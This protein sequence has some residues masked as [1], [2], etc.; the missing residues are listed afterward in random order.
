M[1]NVH[2]ITMIV[3]QILMRILRKQKNPNVSSPAQLPEAMRYGDAPGRQRAGIKGQ[4]KQYRYFKRMEYLSKLAAR[5]ERD[6][7]CLRIAN[8]A[9]RTEPFVSDPNIRQISNSDDDDDEFEDDEFMTAFRAR[10]IDE[11]KRNA[12]RP[13]FGSMRQCVSKAQYIAAIDNEDSRVITIVHLFDTS[14]PS[15]RHLE[16]LLVQLASRRSD[17]CFLSMTIEEAECSQHE[18]DNSVLPILVLYRSGEV[19]DTLFRVTDSLLQGNSNTDADL[20]NLINNS[21][22]SIH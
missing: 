12:S 18:F 22:Q 6:A 1:R 20:E 10:R 13:R 21:L 14:L 2:V 19:V 3:N 4:L 5:A 16:A 15:S 7:N 11:L 9:V 8:G 17:I